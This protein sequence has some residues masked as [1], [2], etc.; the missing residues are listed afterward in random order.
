MTYD[1]SSVLLL[2]GVGKHQHRV[3]DLDSRVLI[4]I[5]TLV[6]WSTVS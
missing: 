3:N 4:E 6:F 5:N 2:F 1:E